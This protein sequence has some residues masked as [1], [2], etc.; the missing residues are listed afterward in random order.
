MQN[1]IQYCVLNA[2]QFRLRPGISTPFYWKRWSLQILILVMGQRGS[3][4]VQ[5]TSVGLVSS[6]IS[7]IGK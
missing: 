3:V 2:E 6:F 5:L 7:H 4:Q 1:E